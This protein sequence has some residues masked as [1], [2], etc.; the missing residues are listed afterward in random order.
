MQSSGIFS[1]TP[2]FMRYSLSAYMKSA[3]KAAFHNISSLAGLASHMERMQE[4]SLVRMILHSHD[5][6]TLLP[7]FSSGLSLR[8][9][10]PL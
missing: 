9:Q 10:R 3:R 1:G 4:V 5:Q 7:G 8:L 6:M 2:P